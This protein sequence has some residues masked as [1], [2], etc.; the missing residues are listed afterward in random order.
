MNSLCSRPLAATIGNTE[1]Q[2]KIHVHFWIWK[3]QNRI[4]NSNCEQLTG[5]GNFLICM[6]MSHSVKSEKQWKKAKNW[7]GNASTS[8]FMQMSYVP[9]KS[10]FIMFVHMQHVSQSSKLLFTQW[11]L[12]ITRKASRNS[13]ITLL[14]LN[15]SNIKLGRKVS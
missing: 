2:N 12:L 1:M 4:K 7:S 5:G 13:C 10:R 9:Y 11:L 6:L 15:I 14:L 3:K 8:G